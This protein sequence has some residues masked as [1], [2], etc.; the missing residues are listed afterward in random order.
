MLNAKYY[1]ISHSIYSCI[2]I[3]LDIL[4]IIAKNISHYFQLSTDSWHFI[5]EFRPYFSK[6]FILLIVES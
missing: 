2:Y 3:W 1:K 6:C 5:D 4:F